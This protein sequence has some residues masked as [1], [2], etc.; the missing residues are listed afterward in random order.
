MTTKS[1]ENHFLNEPKW[2]T[3]CLHDWN[4]FNSTWHIKSPCI[5]VQSELS[6]FN[7][8]HLICGD[9]IPSGGNAGWATTTEIR[10]IIEIPETTPRLGFHMGNNLKCWGPKQSSLA[11][12]FHKNN[13]KLVVYEFFGTQCRTKLFLNGI[14]EFSSTGG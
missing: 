8:N 4:S 9:R 10:W 3:I 2:T 11:D 12:V 13:K 6:N 1:I 7:N 14:V 5:R